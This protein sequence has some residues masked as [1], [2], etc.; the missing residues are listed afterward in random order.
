MCGTPTY[1][2]YLDWERRFQAVQ[3]QNLELEL[4]ADS[5]THENRDQP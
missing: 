1:N 5:S 4:K 3:N 2:A